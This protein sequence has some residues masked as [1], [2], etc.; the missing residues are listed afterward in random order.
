MIVLAILLACVAQDDFVELQGRMVKE[1]SDDLSSAV[2]KVVVRRSEKSASDGVPSKTLD[3]IINQIPDEFSGTVC[4]SNGLI[5]ASSFCL[6][7]KVDTITV[8][9]GQKE[10]PA[11]IVYNNKESDIALLKIDAKDL[12]VLESADIDSVKQ[13]YFCFLLGAGI[14]SNRALVTHGIISATYRYENQYFQA[15]VKMNYQNLGGTVVDRQGKFLG[16]ACKVNNETPWTQCSGVGFVFKATELK[17]LVDKHGGETSGEGIRLKDLRC[18]E[19]ILKFQD[20]LVGVVSKAANA[21]VFFLVGG[22]GFLISEDGLVLT[23]HHVAGMTQNP[24]HDI[25]INSKR[26]KCKM[27]TSDKF[28]DFALLKVDSDEKFPYLDI[29]DSDLMEIAD[30]VFVVGN[31]FLTGFAKGTPLPDIRRLEGEEKDGKKKKSPIPLPDGNWEATISFGQITSM[32]R[33]QDW[34]LDA[35]QVDAAVNPGNS[36]G[37]LLNTDGKVV[38]IVGRLGLKY[39]DVFWRAFA[40]LGMAISSTHVSR[41]LPHLIK[42]KE[43]FHGYIEGITISD[44]EPDLYETPWQRGDGVLVVGVTDSATGFEPGDLI[45][46]IDKYEI[47]SKERFHGVVGTYPAGTTVKIIVRRKTD[48]G[49]FVSKELDIKLGNPR[50]IKRKH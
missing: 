29:D 8:V 21:Y 31:P 4:S 36:G 13:G 17:K 38:G 3:Q 20:H 26:Y 7:G 46:N 10:Y 15:D 33:Y 6:S 39:L 47:K 18:S 24:V 49:E 37:P 2:V 5:A 22:S 1:I 45:I 50:A 44:P 34:Y 9:H 43:I 30:F 12:L 35:I 32:H 48:D 27:I 14:Y 25:V 41:Y 40:G 42:G 19:Q 23:N 28:S 11:E 16:I